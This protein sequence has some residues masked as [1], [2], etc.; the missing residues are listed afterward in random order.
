M[1]PG[2][3]PKHKRIVRLYKTQTGGRD[4]SDR[5]TTTQFVQL[6]IKIEMWKIE[7]DG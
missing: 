4:Y 5:N 2:N 3:I 6:I 1:T 7:K